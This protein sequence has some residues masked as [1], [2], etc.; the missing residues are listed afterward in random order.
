MK[1]RNLFYGIGGICGAIYDLFVTCIV[2][3]ISV[4]IAA[5]REVGADLSGTEVDNTDINVISSAICIG[6]L[7][8][9]ALSL[10]VAIRA[11]MKRKIPLS[12][13]IILEVIH[14]AILGYLIYIMATNEDKLFW[15]IMIVLAVL[16]ITTYV[17]GMVQHIKDQKKKEISQLTE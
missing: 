15:I 5:C 12:F 7:L 10:I 17:F 11:F 13:I 3:V 1:K 4:I 8:C 6:L 2:I 14:L 9:V 16:L